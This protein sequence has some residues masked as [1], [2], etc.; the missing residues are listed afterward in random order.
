MR[1]LKAFEAETTIFFLPPLESQLIARGW[2]FELANESA[3]G[4][5]IAFMLKLP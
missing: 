5:L 1:N 3:E 2:H 4:N